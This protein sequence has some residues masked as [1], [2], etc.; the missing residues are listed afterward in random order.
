MLNTCVRLFQFQRIPFIDTLFYELITCKGFLCF[1]IHVIIDPVHV[2]Q[3]FKYSAKFRFNHVLALFLSLGTTG[4]I[5]TC[6][7]FPVELV[8]A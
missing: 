7:V 1:G 3:A 5:I 8:G 2:S 6:V 4:S